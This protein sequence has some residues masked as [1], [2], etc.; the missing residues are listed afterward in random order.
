MARTIQMS[1]ILSFTQIFFV[2]YGASPQVRLDYSEIFT[3]ITE[4]RMKNVFFE[5]IWGGWWPP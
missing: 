3:A 1:E 2:G 5:A 4:E